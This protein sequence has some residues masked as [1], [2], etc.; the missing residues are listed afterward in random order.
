[1]PKIRWPDDHPNGQIL[2]FVESSRKV[3]ARARNV[4]PVE[5][6]L[7]ESTAA[8]LNRIEALIDEMVV[9]RSFDELKQL[10]DQVTPLVNEALERMS[11]VRAQ[12]K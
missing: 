3:L 9:G 11:I 4:P 8:M 10:T 6:T 7:V 2:K 5:S 1:M 12:M